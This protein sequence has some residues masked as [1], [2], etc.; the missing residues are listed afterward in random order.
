MS[1]IARDFLLYLAML[2]AVFLLMAAAHSL[3]A[4]LATALFCG[5]MVTPIAVVL[6]LYPLG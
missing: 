2:F 1:R 5:I 4:G 3:E 6:I